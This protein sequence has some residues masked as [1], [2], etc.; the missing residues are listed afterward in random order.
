MLMIS[1]SVVSIVA[2]VTLIMKHL[3]LLK[4]YLQRYLYT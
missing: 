2:V 4:R 1:P 3:A